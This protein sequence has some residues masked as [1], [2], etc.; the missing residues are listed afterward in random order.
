M[1]EERYIATVD[2]GSSNISLSVSVVTAQDI[3]VVY[4][5]KCDSEGIMNGVILNSKNVL[6]CLKPLI[7]EAQNEIGKKLNKLVVNWPRANVK[8]YTVNSSIDRAT[9]DSSVTPEEIRL[10][11]DMAVEKLTGELPESADIYDILAMSYSI[12]ELFQISEDDIVGTIGDKLE[13]SFLAFVG[14]SKVRKGIDKIIDE[15]DGISVASRCFTPAYTSNFVITPEEREHGVALIELGGAITSVSVYY[16]GVI[17]YFR[18]FAFGGKDITNDIRTEGNM[19]QKLAENIKKGYG[20]CMPDKLYS[21]EDKCLQIDS[22]MGPRSTMQVK[23]LAEIINSRMEEIANTCL[24]L[25]GESGY[26]DKLRCGLVLCGGG[27]LMSNCHNLFYSLSGLQTKIAIPRYFGA[28]DE[29][30]H[31][32]MLLSTKDDLSLNCAEDMGL[33]RPAENKDETVTEQSLFAPGEIE[34]KDVEK[35]KEK[36]KEKKK[37]KK[38]VIGEFLNNVGT[39]FENSY[40][41]MGEDDKQ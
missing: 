11:K 30:S 12:D 28:T 19:S 7:E 25:L 21:M 32:A 16:K 1:Q 8:C 36:D 23:Y 17:R 4:F 6:S 14:Q 20:S 9:P 31:E 37:K 10:L 35:P 39:M 27:A 33:H 18:S 22:H 3:K 34:V 38:N 40:N 41:N 13:G 26:A 2:F 24:Y 15:L 5:G 29:C